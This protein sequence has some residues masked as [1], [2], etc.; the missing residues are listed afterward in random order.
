M[1]IMIKMS[2]EE[3]E[4]YKRYL[5]DSKRCLSIVDDIF[6]QKLDM[7]HLPIEIKNFCENIRQKIKYELKHDL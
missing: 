6:K 3:Y 2:E 1:E 5:R 4:N 7:E